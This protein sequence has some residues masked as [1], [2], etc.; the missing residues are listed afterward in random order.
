MLSKQ[1]RK[2]GLHE[3]QL[4]IAEIKKD[5]Q[6][7]LEK[8]KAEQKEVNKTLTTMTATLQSQKKGMQV[9]Q[10]QM[11]IQQTQLYEVRTLQQVQL[12]MMR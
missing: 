3:S 5:Q 8:I 12:K 1:I 10:Q 7:E 2:K 6:K 9:Q 4:Q 11:S